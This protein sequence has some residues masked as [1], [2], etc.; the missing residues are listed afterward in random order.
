MNQLRHTQKLQVEFWHLDLF[1]TSV[2]LFYLF[3]EGSGPL[4]SCQSRHKPIRLE[5]MSITQQ[6]M[7]E[8]QS[9]QFLVEYCLSRMR[10]EVCNDDT[11]LSSV[12]YQLFQ[13]WLQ[14][15]E[16]SWCGHCGW[17]T[18][19]IVTCWEASVANVKKGN[20]R[21]VFICQ[22]YQTPDPRRLLQYP[23]SNDLAS[24][25]IWISGST[26]HRF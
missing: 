2:P 6:V 10:S 23:S 4:G 13:L 16:G 12:F 7:H 3:L 26:W 17:M 15:T 19:W 9:L 22:E 20:S 5:I 21:S 14:V 25:W 11:Q 8:K 18:G 24:L 1:D